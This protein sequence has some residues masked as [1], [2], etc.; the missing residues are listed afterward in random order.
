M[1]APSQRAGV[2]RT[3]HS[4]LTRAR[5]ALAALVAALLLALA[6]S[7]AGGGGELRGTP[8]QPT[9]PTAS[10]G[11]TPNEQARQVGA[12]ANTPAAAADAA[13]VSAP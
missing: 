11:P 13:P 1:L 8:I 6:M 10:A 5:W 4:R 7:W 3:R 12:A 2:S 9:A